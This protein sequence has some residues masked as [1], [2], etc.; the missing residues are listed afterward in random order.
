M[1]GEEATVDQLVDPTGAGG[2]AAGDAGAL[3][4]E[5]EAGDE[6]AEEHEAGG[7]LVEGDGSDVEVDPVGDAPEGALAEDEEAGDLVE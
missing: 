7:P 6:L 4:H 1:N 5:P 2:E 3:H